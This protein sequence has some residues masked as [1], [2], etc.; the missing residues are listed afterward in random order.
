MAFL[1]GLFNWVGNAV[2]TILGGNASRADQQQYNVQNMGIQQQFAEKN[3]AIQNK[4]NVEAFNAENE[5]NSPIAQ[6]LRMEQAGLNPNWDTP[7]QVVGQMDSATPASSP[8][9]GMPSGSNAGS[10]GDLIGVVSSLKDL[11][12]KQS[13][14]DLNDELAKKAKEDARKAGEDA[15]QT[16][17]QNWLNEHYGAP[18]KEADIAKTTSEGLLSRSA[19]F[20]EISAC[21][22]PKT[23]SADF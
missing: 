8:S 18:A 2:N 20:F 14:I 13:Q 9:G 22:R 10:L 4:Y 12:V 21:A 3:M 17:F 11:K 1:G 16:S 23:C 5:Y 19:S 7:G 6:R 15:D